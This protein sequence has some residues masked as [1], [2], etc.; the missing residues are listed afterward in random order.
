[1]GIVIGSGTT[2]INFC[3]ILFEWFKFFFLFWEGVVY[4]HYFFLVSSFLAVFDTL[5]GSDLFW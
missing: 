1:M 5:A 3:G 2:I 4:L